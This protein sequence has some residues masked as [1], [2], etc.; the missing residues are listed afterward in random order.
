LRRI[1]G[2]KPSCR[3]AHMHSVTLECSDYNCHYTIDGT[4][5]RD[6]ELGLKTQTVSIAMR[7]AI[8][9]SNAGFRLIVRARE[10]AMGARFIG[11][12]FRVSECRVLSTFA[13][14]PAYPSF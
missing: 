13:G 2:G 9:R 5:L 8:V 6:E 4:A 3:C 7:T 11:C 12:R 14:E 1:F 10:N